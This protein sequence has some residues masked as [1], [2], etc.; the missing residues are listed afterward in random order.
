[1]DA[2]E[3]YFWLDDID[4]IGP[5]NVGNDREVSVIDVA[6][7]ITELV[8][9]TRIKWCDP[10]PQDPTNRRPDLTLNRKILPGWDARISYEEGIKRTLDWFREKVMAGA[11]T[12][13]PTPIR[14][15]S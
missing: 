14:L 12:V 11:E 2:L 6:K 7:F 10:I 13:A 1:V 3:R 5:L 15:E 9:G 8:P 4:Y